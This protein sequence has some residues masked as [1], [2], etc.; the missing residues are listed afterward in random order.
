[1]SRTS[2]GQ[3]HDLTRHEEPPAL[4]SANSA[5]R[6]HLQE[7]YQQPTLNFHEEVETFL[8]MRE[9]CTPLLS[10]RPRGTGNPV[11]QL[12]GRRELL[13]RQG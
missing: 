3:R 1:M 8:F 6:P 5:V 10:R 12:G 7:K 9:K 2:L 11:P 13:L 4:R